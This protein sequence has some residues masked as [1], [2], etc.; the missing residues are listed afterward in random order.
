MG[1][2]NKEQLIHWLES[3]FLKTKGFEVSKRLDWLDYGLF[4]FTENYKE[5]ESYSTSTEKPETAIDM[6]KDKDYSTL[7]QGQLVRHLHNFLVAS[8]SLVEHTRSSMR[9]WYKNTELLKA[10]EHKIKEEFVDDPLTSF[11]ES[12]RNY[13]VHKSPLGKTG[14]DTVLDSKHYFA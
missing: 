14:S 8:K 11:I 10:Y 12:L 6:M 1:N 4:I 5:L 13:C 2:V 3:E 9:E 7:V